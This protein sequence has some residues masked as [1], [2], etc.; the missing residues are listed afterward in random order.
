MKAVIFDLDGTLL[1]TLEDLT[2]ATNVALKHYGFPSRSLE[3]VRSFVGNGVKNLMLRA[4]PEGTEETV[5]EDCLKVFKSHYE[6]HKQDKTAPYSGIMELLEALAKKGVQ[7]GIVSNKFDVA[8]KELNAF[9]FGEYIDVAIGESAKVAKK[10]APDAVY[11]A[12]EEMGVAKD[13]VLYVGDSE[14]DVMTAKN[15]GVAMI[16]VTWGFRTEEVLRRTG[17]DCIIH[18]PMELLEHLV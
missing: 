10:P 17:A 4:V 11:Q 15:A 5:V 18:N 13:D 16:G 8:V 9:Y 12:L 2:D 3:E 14:T 6:L 1:N 7:M